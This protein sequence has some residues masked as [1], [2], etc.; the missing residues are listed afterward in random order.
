MKKLSLLI[1][2]ILIVEGA[3]AQL[4]RAQLNKIL[5][6]T[7]YPYKRA[8]QIN[9]SFHNIL[10]D[11]TA[12]IRGTN[13][14]TANTI[15]N[16]TGTFS[17]T[18]SGLFTLAPD[19]VSL[20]GTKIRFIN[21]AGVNKLLTSDANGYA[22]WQTNI[23][24]PLI[25]GGTGTTST[26]KLKSTSGVGTTGAGIIFQVGNN[27]GTEA[28][29]I[30][31]S[32]ELLIG[33]SAKLSTWESL[34]VQKNQN[35]LSGQ[36]IANTTSGAAARA[37]LSI[38]TSA[39]NS[40]DLTFQIFSAGYT[41]SGMSVA[42]TGSLISNAAAG[43]NI[44][45]INATQLAL[46]TNAIERMRITTDGDFG[47]G[48]VV[49]AQK[50]HIR[51][52]VN[53][54][55]SFQIDNAN[56]GASAYTSVMVTNG[57]VVGDSIRVIALGTGW[58][59]TGAFVQDSGV[60]STELNMSGGLSIGTRHAS[61]P[62]RFFSGGHTN[63]RARITETGLVGIGQTVPTGQCHIKQPSLTGAIPVL[64]LEQLDVSEQFFDFITT[65]G[66]GN[67]IEAAGA[68]VLSTTHFIKITIPGGLTRFIPCGTIA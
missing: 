53:G 22:T 66:V 50:F 54:E 43:F 62:I 7:A 32:G 23:I 51:K 4:T 5:N 16:A 37:A 24:A 28:M 38:T 60:I 33:A 13:T 68:K 65:I 35:A 6:S 17:W 30:L 40:S 44:G 36:I 56:T 47:I 14:Y 46:W 48:L 10:D 9:L 15:I 31:N 29:R 1:L 12:L 55:T 57:T 8:S 34:L 61:A 63:E 3:M 49:P 18:T 52:N 21:G 42:D 20:T 39:T 67:A 45:T 19:S 26:L 64:T 2:S 58:T 25:T 41:T 27:G 11:G 59:T